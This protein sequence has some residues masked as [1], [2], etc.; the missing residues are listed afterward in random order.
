MLVPLALTHREMICRERRRA[1]LSP[2]AGGLGSR[3]ILPCQLRAAQ[4]PA[5]RVTGRL[6]DIPR[7]PQQSQAPGLS[8]Q[9]S[10]NKECGLNL[11]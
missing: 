7:A 6:A 5:L 1:S 4:P 8:S 2:S 9:L 11:S 10:A 3:S